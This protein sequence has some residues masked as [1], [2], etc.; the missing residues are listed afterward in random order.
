MKVSITVEAGTLP[1]QFMPAQQQFSRIVITGAGSGLGRA[2]ALRFARAGARVAVTDLDPDRAAATLDAVCAAGATGFSMRC[3]V[4]AAP[5]FTA[6]AQRLH[7]Q[8]SGVDVVINNAGVA[9]AGTTI[10][11]S[12]EDWHWTLDIDLFGVVRGCHT[13]APLLVRQGSGHIVNIASFAGIANA[14]A[15]AAYNTAKAGV[16]ALSETLRAEMDA[17]GVGVTVACPSF[18]RTNLL[19]EFRTPD[20]GLKQMAEKMFARAKVTADEVADDI[21]A[22]VQ[23]NRF[24]VITHPEA[25]WLYRFKRL[26]PETFFR[27]VRRQAA[28]FTRNRARTGS[29]R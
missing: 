29:D 14:P 9:S 28:G 22:A 21:Y 2:L 27:T 19:E 1:P 7:E 4:R 18:F 11:T 10:D 12:L 8:W 3:D 25:R 24:L 16:I 26:A 20:P 13:L 5:D 23:T 17:H 15:M 6:L